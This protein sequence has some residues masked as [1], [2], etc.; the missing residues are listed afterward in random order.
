MSFLNRIFK[1]GNNQQENNN[2]EEPAK[3]IYQK[4]KEASEIEYIR[5]ELEKKN[6]I[7]LIVK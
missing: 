4:L 3:R 2:K 5:F 1:K 7:F 6:H